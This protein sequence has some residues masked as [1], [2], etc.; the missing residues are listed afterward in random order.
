MKYLIVTIALSI[1][2]LIPYRTS[3]NLCSQFDYLIITI[4]MTYSPIPIIGGRAIAKANPQIRYTHGKD[5]NVLLVVKC[6]DL[7]FFNTD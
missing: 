7:S 4:S 5:M 2:A 1:F 6:Q 3:I